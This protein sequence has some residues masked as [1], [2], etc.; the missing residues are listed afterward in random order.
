MC[1]VLRVMSCPAWRISSA[2]VASGRAVD[3]RG[4]RIRLCHGERIEPGGE[5][6]V[7]ALAGKV[8]CGLAGFALVVWI[9]TVSEEKLGQVAA[10]GGCSGEEGC[11]S[12]GLDGI[13][14]GATVEEEADYFGILVQG[15]GGMEGLVLLGVAAEGVDSGAGIE[16][17][18]D[19]L[20][21]GKGGGEVQGRPAVAGVVV[22]ELRFGSEQAIQLG[23]V[24][25]GGCFKDVEAAAVRGK[26]LEEE[27][28]DEGLREVDRPA[29]CGYALGIAPDGERGVVVDLFSNFG[30]CACL[31]EFEEGCGHGSKISAIGVRGASKVRTHRSKILAISFR[32]MYE[33]I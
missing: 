15:E 10:V 13:D 4:V 8:G 24:A 2:T 27:V 29:E 20:R 30:G 9:G 6:G 26:P 22:C 5:I 19:G 11:E 3:G 32:F 1:L 33:L 23:Q 14:G 7:A 12:A 18:L 28:A 21:G 31:N 17:R 16:Q 25:D